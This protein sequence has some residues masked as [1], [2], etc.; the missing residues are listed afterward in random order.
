MP[1]WLALVVLL[2]VGCEQEEAVRLYNDWGFACSGVVVSPG[3]ILTAGHCANAPL[4]FEGRRIVAKPIQVGV[5]AVVLQAPWAKGQVQWGMR[6][7]VGDRM[8]V[9]GY[10]CTKGGRAET[11]FGTV[12]AVWW[13]QVYTNI[14]GCLGDSGSPMFDSKHRLIGLV[15]Y[16]T[17]KGDLVGRRVWP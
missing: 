11:R 4:S 10:G 6:A 2:S 12:T 8:Q 3:R 14:K 17:D 13:D 5:D 16:R 9:V 1:R 7:M 15:T